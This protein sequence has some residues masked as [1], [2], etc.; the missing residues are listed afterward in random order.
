MI[1]DAYVDGKELPNTSFTAGWLL[2]KLVTNCDS[3]AVA[4]KES[5]VKNVT[6]KRIAEGEGYL[7]HIYRYSIEFTDCRQPSF[8][9][10]AKIPLVHNFGVKA[11]DEE[12]KKFITERI[13]EGD[14]FLSHIYRYSIEFTQCG[15]PTFSCVAKVPLVHNFGVEATDEET[16]EKQHRE[17]VERHNRECAFYETL[18][19]VDGL[20]L[21]RIFFAQTMAEDSDDAGML[22][23]IPQFCSDACGSA[24]GVQTLRRGY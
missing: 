19:D 7:S 17:M 13:A 6:S 12:T 4:A 20:P 3:F 10:V 24:S 23:I 1:C 8:Q 21:P 2:E 18:K 22:R 14:G 15:Q 16:R 5:A 11:A 9:C